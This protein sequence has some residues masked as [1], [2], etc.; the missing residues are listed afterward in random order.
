M[1]LIS[2]IIPVYNSQNTIKETIESVLTQ[3]FTDFELIIINDG[4]QDSSLA[5]IGQVKDERIRVFSYPQAGANASRNRGVDR[6]KG[7]YISFLDADDLWTADKLECQLKALQDN[8]E[9]AVAYS[10]TNC[11]DESGKFLRRG[12]YR[13]CSGE[14]YAQLLLIDFLENGSNPLIRRE[15]LTTVGKFDQ[16]LTHAEDW[17]MWLRLAASYPFVAVPSPQILYRVS[18]DSASNNLVKMEADCL[19]VIERSFARASPSIQHLKRYS[20]ANIYIYLIYKALAGSPSRE[21]GKLAARFLRQ[22]IRYNPSLLKAPVLAKI[23]LNVVAFRVMTPKQ[24][25]LFL[26]Q[27]GGLS[28][29]EAWL[30]YLK[31]EPG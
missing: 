3:S 11:I 23:L 18:A 28:K 9:A 7:D 1:A 27:M 10:W 29:I 8:P 19:R 16:S 31:V 5:V 4:F 14:V 15:A 20:I 2:I 24:A 21:K 12:S 6:A 26:S 22:V 13:S 17:D 25:Q 30:G